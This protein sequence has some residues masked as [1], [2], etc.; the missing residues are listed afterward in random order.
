M[1]PCKNLDL[2]FNHIYGYRSDLH[3]AI[4]ALHVKA[5]IP[6]L[7]ISRETECEMS[8]ASFSHSAGSNGTPLDEIDKIG[9]L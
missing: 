8:G 9:S 4:S 6:S 5:I 7:K 3:A 2:P 1:V